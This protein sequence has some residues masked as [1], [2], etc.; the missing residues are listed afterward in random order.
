MPMKVCHPEN[1]SG[2]CTGH[3]PV[4]IFIGRE[5]P[6]VK[7]RQRQAGMGGYEK[8]NEV[9]EEKGGRLR[10]NEIIWV[11]YYLICN[12]PFVPLST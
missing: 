7:G 8:Q 3:C 10:R 6:A 5:A 9:G 1:N 4:H 2:D 11:I 12:S